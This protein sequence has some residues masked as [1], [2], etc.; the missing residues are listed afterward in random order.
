MG[1]APVRHR[2]SPAGLSGERP[3]S[4]D[5][6]QPGAAGLKRHGPAIGSVSGFVVHLA[7]LGYTQIL[8]LHSA[9]HELFVGGAESSWLMILLPMFVI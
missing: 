1:R 5:R 3:G 9:S 4:R 2:A 6:R 8:A 7:E